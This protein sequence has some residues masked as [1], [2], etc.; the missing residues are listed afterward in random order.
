MPQSPR[1]GSAADKVMTMPNYLYGVVYRGGVIWNREPQSFPGSA[2]EFARE[3]LLTW[4]AENSE[5]ANEIV[6]VNVWDADREGAGVPAKIIGR[7]SSHQLDEGPFDPDQIYLPYGQYSIYSVGYDF[8]HD[9][10][11]LAPGGGHSIPHTPYGLIAAGEGPALAIR[12]GHEGWISLQVALRDGEPPADLEAWEAVEQVTMKPAGEVRVADITG[13]IEDHY[14]DLRGG[15]DTGHL[16]IRVSVRGRD[17][18]A[19]PASA[20]ALH[21]RRAPWEDHLIEAWPVTRPAPQVVLKRDEFSR[22][23][24]TSHRDSR[25]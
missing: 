15:H 9:D 7:M 22:R 1:P 19:L 23:W 14:P 20:G 18:L 24:E 21:P 17:R 16:A 10:P 2:Q 13:V 11:V 4:M 3:K 12:A 8:F 5:N 25:S 6:V